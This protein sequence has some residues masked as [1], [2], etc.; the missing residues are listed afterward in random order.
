MTH[1]PVQSSKLSTERRVDVGAH[2][3]GATQ[4]RERRKGIN[5]ALARD[6]QSVFKGKPGE[7][8]NMLQKSTEKEVKE[9][10]EVVD[11]GYW[12]SLL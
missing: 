2:W 11:I 5:K 7:Q 12:E 10:A 6:V 9:R 4:H 1:F 8:L 3:V